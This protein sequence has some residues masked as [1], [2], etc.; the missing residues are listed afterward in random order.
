VATSNPRVPFCLQFDL[1]GYGQDFTRTDNGQRRDI[2][3]NNPA[4]E[5]N[6]RE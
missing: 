4:E 2:H 6:N 3:Q 5:L 1:T